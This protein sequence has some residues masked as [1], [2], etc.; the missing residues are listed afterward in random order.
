MQRGGTAAIKGLVIDGV[1]GNPI[2]RARVRLMSGPAA[3][4]SP[5]LTDS[6]GAFE[7]TGLPE[8][9]HNLMVENPR[10]WRPDSRTSIDRCAPD[11]CR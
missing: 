5:I 7:L 10:T 3:S 11:W 4:R 1:T 2:P 9:P 8:G 6:T